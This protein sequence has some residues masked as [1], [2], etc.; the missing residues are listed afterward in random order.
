[1]NQKVVNTENH[2]GVKNEPSNA[3]SS[4]TSTLSTSFNAAT[5]Y[6]PTASLL[7]G[8]ISQSL[9]G[10][11]KASEDD[12]REWTRTYH[13][14]TLNLLNFPTN[15]S[16]NRVNYRTVMNRA[17]IGIVTSAA[18]SL[19][20]LRQALQNSIN[21]EI[22]TIL[23][24][25]IEKY[26]R[27]SISNIRK[28]FGANSVSEQ[29]LQ[30]ACR[31]ILEEAKKMYIGSNVNSSNSA[32][33]NSPSNGELIENGSDYENNTI[34]SGTKRRHHHHH[35]PINQLFDYES[36]SES[37]SFHNH[38]L[39]P[40]PVKRKK[41]KGTSVVGKVKSTPAKVQVKGNSSI[42]IKR[43]GPRWDPNRLSTETRF[44]LGSK[45]NKALGFGAT[46][47]RLYTKHADLFRY[48]GDQEDKQWLHEHGFM[49]P[50]GGKAYLI[51]KEDIEDLLISDEY[52]DA[53]GVDGDSM[54]VGFTVPSYIIDKMKKTMEALR[55]ES[56][57][58]NLMKNNSLVPPVIELAPPGQNC[59]IVENSS[60][61]P[62][63]SVDLDYLSSNVDL[64]PS[65]SPLPTDLSLTS[66]DI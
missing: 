56:A 11:L 6:T 41:F 14:R 36:D 9:D 43:E 19:N 16:S 48:I 1:M 23:Q 54:G 51:I 13:M 4:S 10:N 21:N 25:Y 57:R 62:S 39:R 26:F 47:G 28:N 45:A 65:I 55:N 53:P 31:Q 37:N 42:D 8:P 58:S 18:K 66:N 24:K 49:P 2:L 60:R 52:R 40:P 34:I 17:R 64:S 35:L 38:H 20:V 44:V 12:L 7:T 46:R 59:D 50:A 27:P 29:H 15:A 63:P 32:P 3:S 33:V 30:A 61:G 5:T 22:N